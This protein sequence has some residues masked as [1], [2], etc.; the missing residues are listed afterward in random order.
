ML[1]IAS[2]SYIFLSILCRHYLGDVFVFVNNNGY[3]ID[4]YKHRD[5]KLKV[6]THKLLDFLL[7]SLTHQSDLM[8]DIEYKVELSVSLTEF[9]T[10]CG[11]AV[12]YANRAKVRKQVKSDLEFLK[13]LRVNT[14]EKR[15]RKIINYGPFHLLDKGWVKGDYI[16]IVFNRDFILYLKEIRMFMTYP[17]ALFKTDNKTNSYY[18]GKK[19][20]YH[21]GLYSNRK[22]GLNYISVRRLLVYAPNL[23]SYRQYEVT[24][25]L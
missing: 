14:S 5:C 24:S 8:R 22:K 13:I 2:H 20:V 25:H 15:N 9:M 6:S 11:L 18:L 17:L 1:H 16:N 3:Y 12:T 7:I 4:R 23:P 10:L 21:Y 19:L